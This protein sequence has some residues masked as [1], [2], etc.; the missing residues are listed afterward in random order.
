MRWSPLVGSFCGSFL[1]T[2][3]IA[4]LNLGPRIC[5]RPRIALSWSTFLFLL[6][7]YKPHAFSSLSRPLLLSLLQTHHTPHTAQDNQDN[8]AKTEPARLPASGNVGAR[9]ESASFQGP[10]ACRSRTRED[11]LRRHERMSF[12]DARGCPSRIRED[13]L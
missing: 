10:R 5:L 13:V 11:V 6:L 3:S 8:Q 4:F 2:S 1:H 9:L 7:I 12:E